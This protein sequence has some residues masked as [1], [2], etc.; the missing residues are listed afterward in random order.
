MRLSRSGDLDTHPVEY[1]PIEDDNRCMPRVRM[2]KLTYVALGAPNGVTICRRSAFR[3]IAL[4]L[5]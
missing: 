3:E 5:F 4:T 1:F 2:N